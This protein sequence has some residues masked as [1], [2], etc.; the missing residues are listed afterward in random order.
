MNHKFS[1]TWLMFC[2]MAFS[3]GSYTGSNTPRLES[4]QE[5]VSNALYDGVKYGKQPVCTINSKNA[6]KYTKPIKAIAMGYKY[7]NLRV[8]VIENEK[9]TCIA[10]CVKRSYG[11]RVN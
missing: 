2:Y 6:L 7:L 9:I 10:N 8:E 5:C 11:M 4:W 1:I 3:A